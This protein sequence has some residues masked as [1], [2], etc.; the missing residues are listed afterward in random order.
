MLKTL[1]NKNYK[2]RSLSHSLTCFNNSF[3][4]NSN[5]SLSATWIWSQTYTTNS[6]SYSSSICFN[7]SKTLRLLCSP[8]R[9]LLETLLPFLT[10]Q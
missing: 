2:I 1:N 8:L 9:C 10:S 4:L 3:L 7:N 6:K 5:S